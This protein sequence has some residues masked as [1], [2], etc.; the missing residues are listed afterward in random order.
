MTNPYTKNLDSGLFGWRIVVLS[1]GHPCNIAFFVD[2]LVYPAFGPS[3]F[4][5]PVANRPC[6]LSVLLSFST[7]V[8]SIGRAFSAALFGSLFHQRC[9]ASLH[10]SSFLFLSQFSRPLLIPVVQSCSPF[11]FHFLSNCCSLLRIRNSDLLCW[12]LQLFFFFSSHP[13]LPSFPLCFKIIFLVRYQSVVNVKLIQVLSEQ[14][15]SHLCVSF[16]SSQNLLQDFF[17]T[18]FL[19]FFSFLCFILLFYFFILFEPISPMR[20]RCRSELYIL[21]CGSPHCC[22]LNFVH[23]VDRH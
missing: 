21:F 2:F 13:H 9:S 4:L 6:L 15:Y 1:R 14:L 5:A 20:K 16:K 23:F 8:F 18:I 11:A 3:Q 17:V 19:C 22:C 7:N 10:P 12:P